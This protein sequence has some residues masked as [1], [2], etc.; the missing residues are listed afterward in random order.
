MRTDSSVRKTGLVLAVCLGVAVAGCSSDD[1]ADSADSS[2]TFYGQSTDIGNGSARTFVALDA[3][4]NPSEVGIRLT[5][6]ALDGLPEHQGKPAEVFTLEFP[7]QVSGTPFEFATLD[8]NNHGHEPAGLFDKPH[9]DSHYFMMDEEKV[10]AIVP[11]DPDFAAKAAKLPEPQYVPKDYVPAPVPA[12]P[13]MGA[14]WVDSTAGLAPGAD[15]TQVFING[16]WDGEYNFL[17]PMMT[18]D[19]LLTKPSLTEDIK[20]PQAYQK[21]GYYPTVY[22][23]AFD[24]EADE[25]VFTLG[26]MTHRDES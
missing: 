6:A 1:S 25:Y 24:D 9:F 22:S 7:E 17:E 12:V 4:G 2:G 8:W 13:Q 26:G 19:W 3:E 23:V 14:H 16:S 15:F 18:R 20:Q 5:E 11:S 10:A 21:S